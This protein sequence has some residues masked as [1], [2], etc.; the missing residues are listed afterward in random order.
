MN[1][2]IFAVFFLAF[3]LVLFLPE[4]S[5]YSGNR[6]EY[7]EDKM[8]DQFITIH[9]LIRSLKD[10]NREIRKKVRELERRLNK[11]TERVM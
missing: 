11:L 7:L 3:S 8:D 9:K 6:F 4:S 5:I 1:K 10:E 2:T